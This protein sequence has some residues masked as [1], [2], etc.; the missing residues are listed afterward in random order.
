MPGLDLLTPA[1]QLNINGTITQPASQ[2]A[3]E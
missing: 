1:V 2:D 3:F